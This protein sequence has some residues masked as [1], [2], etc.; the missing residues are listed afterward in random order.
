MQGEA[1]QTHPPPRLQRWHHLQQLA[2]ALSATTV[3]HRLHLH[4]LVQVKTELPLLLH[5]QPQPQKQLQ[6][7]QR[8]RI[9]QKQGV[10]SSW[11]TGW[12]ALSPAATSERPRQPHRQHQSRL[13]ARRRCYQVALARQ[14][15]LQHR[16]AQLRQLYCY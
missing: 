2:I 16:L 4:L 15:L 8:L 1:A 5:L 12:R 9:Q 13:L 7:N 11:A 10:A 3:A 14:Q 6:L